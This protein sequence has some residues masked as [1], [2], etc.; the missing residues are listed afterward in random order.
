MRAGWMSW[1]LGCYSLAIYFLTSLWYNVKE[2][3]VEY[4]SYVLLYL[5]VTGLGSFGICYRL[6]K[7]QNLSHPLLSCL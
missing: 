5:F 6:G 1:I 3:L 2:L 4:H 7:L